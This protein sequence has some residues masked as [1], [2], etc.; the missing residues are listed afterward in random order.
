MK[1]NRLINNNVMNKPLILL[2]IL[3]SCL[4]ACKKYEEGP[5][6][7]LKTAASR[8][9]GSWI[10][11]GGSWYEVATDSGAAYITWIEEYTKENAFSLSKGWFENGASFNYT[12]EGSWEWLD[13]KE[14]IKITKAND[15]TYTFTINKLTSSEFMYTDS[16]GYTYEFFKKE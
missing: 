6:F 5:S 13:K 15:S 16:L 9:E 1:T 12:T 10:L 14:G 8:L 7:T 3:N 2:L 11:T 4:V